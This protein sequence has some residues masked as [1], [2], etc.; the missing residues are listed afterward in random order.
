MGHRYKY[1]SYREKRNDY[2]I[3]LKVDGIVVTKS[4]STLQ[5][6]LTVRSELMKQFHLDK[7]LLLKIHG[8]EATVPV[9][10]LSEAFDTFLAESVCK[11][12]LTPSTMYKYEE[13]KRLVNP[14]LGKLRIDEI[15][16]DIWQDTFSALQSQRKLSYNY[17][18]ANV[19]RYRRMYEWYIKR[20]QVQE[21][22]IRY[23]E[24][25]KTPQEKRR[26]FTAG[27]KNRFLQTARTYDYQ[28]FFMFNLLFESGMRRGELLALQ[29]QDIE[30]HEGFLHVNKS[31][32]KGIVDGEYKEFCGRTKTAASVRNIPLS[33]KTSFMLKVFH[34]QK[35]PKAEDFVFTLKNS[36]S[37]Y[38]WVSLSRIDYVFALIRDM[39]G[40]DKRLSIHAIRHYVVSKLM[41]ANVDIKT[42]QEIGGWAKASTL[43]DIYAH[44]NEEAKRQAMRT[45]LFTT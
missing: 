27:E 19:G 4:A 20:G 21:N 25:Q 44:S 31:I 16:Q 12:G 39:A 29:W 37:K 43:L 11:E 36:W 15:R 24:L 45:A 1:I 23:I 42:V 5:E 38:P 32:S 33:N 30:F 17:L 35:N 7:N 3:R 14:I 22:P 18:K 8:R 13:A 40:L 2:L 41:M 26:V 34:E 9:P 10:K 6:A 28:F